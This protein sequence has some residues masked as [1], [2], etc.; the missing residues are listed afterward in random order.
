MPERGERLGHG[1]KLGLGQA[2]TEFSFDELVV[3]GEG[4]IVA[5][6]AFGCQDHLHAPPIAFDGFATDQ[7]SRLDPVH[8]TGQS[9]PG[10]QGALLELLHPQAVIRGVI[11]LGQHVEP[12]QWKSGPG[13]EIGLSN[14]E[15]PRGRKEDASPGVVHEPGGPA[16]VFILRHVPTIEGFLCPCNFSQIS[17]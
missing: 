1:S 8:E 9:A 14:L 6:A 15:R 4:G 17:S 13:D 7:S 11:E 12:G 5:P 10:E 16:G 2:A 3:V